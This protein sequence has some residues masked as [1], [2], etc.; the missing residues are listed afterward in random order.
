MWSSSNV[1]DP[2]D[3]QSS[4]CLPH[5]NCLQHNSVMQAVNVYCPH[6]NNVPF[7]CDGIMQAVKAGEKGEF[8]IIWLAAEAA[9][10]AELTR[11]GCL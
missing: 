10:D 7:S 5:Q 8:V 9:E 1:A 3:K 2:E 11:S 4:S 6:H